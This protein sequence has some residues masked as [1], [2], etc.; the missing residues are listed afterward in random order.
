MI[1]F[2]ILL[3]INLVYRVHSYHVVTDQGPV[4]WFIAN[5]YCVDNYNTNLATI[6]DFWIG[7]NDL[8]TSGTWIHADGYDCGIY[9]NADNNC[10][11]EIICINNL[12]LGHSSTIL[13]MSTL[14][15][16]LFLMLSHKEVFVLVY[17]LWLSRLTNSKE[18]VV[19]SSGH[20][21]DHSAHNLVDINLQTYF[22]SQNPNS[23]LS[24][25]TFPVWVVFDFEVPG[26]LNKFWYYG[27]DTTHDVSSSKLQYS[28][29][30][31]G[32]WYDYKN[33]N[34]SQSGSMWQ[35][36]TFTDSPYRQ[37]WRWYIYATY[38][39]WE[40]VVKEVDFEFETKQ[41]TRSPTKSPSK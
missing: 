18:T 15:C 13:A 34:P 40:V 32:P 38:S 23:C 19:L 3:S 41:P 16:I 35:D 4:N 10:N 25:V 36:W 37:Y 17:V 20:D 22:D 31:L 2:I 5:Q 1:R 26:K 7:I 8:D 30:Q 12:D 21:A 39:G 33:I 6:I 28:T 29:S 27:F 24:C 14:F 9:A 11:N